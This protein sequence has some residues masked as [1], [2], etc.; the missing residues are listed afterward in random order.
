MSR[1]ARSPLGSLAIALLLAPSLAGC[2]STQR[3]PF[4]D[5]A[6]LD[7]IVGVT[8]CSGAEIPFA[9]R[10]ALITNDTL[11]SVS[12]QGQLTLPTDS[13]AWAWT[14]KFSVARTVG[15]VVGLLLVT[16]VESGRLGDTQLFPEDDH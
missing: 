15:L 12:R 1:A 10:G 7:R 16:A 4:N 5:T 3:I 11:Y 8:T 6:Q 14:R 2:M 13:I 9:V